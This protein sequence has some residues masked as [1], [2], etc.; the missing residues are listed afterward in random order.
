MADIEA[1]DLSGRAYS[2]K[3]AK[4][5]YPVNLGSVDLLVAFDDFEKAHAGEELSVSGWRQ[6]VETGIL[7][8]VRAVVSKAFSDPADAEEIVATGDARIWIDAFIQTAS[9]LKDGGGWSDLDDA[10]ARYIPAQ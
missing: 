2:A 8:E 5:V 3:L 4:E 1:V 7:G 9:M 6:L 10:I